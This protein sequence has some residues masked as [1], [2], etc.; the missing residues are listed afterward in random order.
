[1]W[2]GGSWGSATHPRAR[3]QLLPLELGVLI[4]ECS[5]VRQ[6]REQLGVSLE[7]LLLSLNNKLD[8]AEN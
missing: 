6:W 4:T 7:A 2:A 3:S 5:A 8:T 1:M